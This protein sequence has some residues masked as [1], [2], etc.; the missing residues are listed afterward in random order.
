[1]AIQIADNFSYQGKKPLDGR[2]QF[3]TLADMVAASADVLYDGCLAY[4]KGNKKYYTYDSTNDVD[5]T[6]GKWR[7]LETGTTGDFIPTSEK[8]SN[9]G[10]AELDSSGKVPASQL[11]SYVDDVKSY[12]TKNDFPA[13]GEDDKIYIAKQVLVSQNSSFTQK[14]SNI[15]AIEKGKL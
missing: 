13:V 1:M 5:G 2:V 9:G 10:V 7:E 4:V 8:G 14:G 3:N 15:K 6:L 12:P 11:P